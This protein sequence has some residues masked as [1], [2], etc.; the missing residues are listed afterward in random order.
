MEQGICKFR[1]V[2]NASDKPERF[3]SADGGTRYGPSPAELQRRFL[4]ALH[5]DGY[6]P[7]DGDADGFQYW[8][9]PVA[10]PAGV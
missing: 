5:K 7:F 3:W 8:R 6:E 4:A 10:P 2:D 1:F 9:R